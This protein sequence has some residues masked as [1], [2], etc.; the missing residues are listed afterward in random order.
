V[1]LGAG[2]KAVVVVAPNWLG[3]AVMALPALA[4]LRRHFTGARLA[5]AAR[6]SIAPLFEMVEGVDEV[7]TLPGSGGWRSIVTSDGDVAALASRFDIAILLPNSF[8]SALTARRA[9]IPERWGTAT[10]LRARLLTRA[11]ARP[12]GTLHQAAYYQA[13]VAA[14]GIPNG[15]R[16]A[17]VVVPRSTPG[18]PGTPGTRLRADEPPSASAGQALGTYVVLAPGAAYG[19]AKQWPPDRFA[20]LAALI[21]R[22]TDWNVVL[23]GSRADQAVC[24]SI[25]ADESRLI[26]LCGQTDLAALARILAGA[27]AVV[28]ND[29]GAMHLAGAVAARVIAVFGATNEHRT[30]PLAPGPDAPPPAILTHPVWCRPCMLRECPLDHR[31]MTGISAARVFAALD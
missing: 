5:V 28:T 7:V 30:S 11:V 3:D 2:G 16:Y 25:A 19:S 26:N 18:T 15:P 6:R 13:I 17:R 29:S 1:S 31:C 27:R 4:D 23:V 12:Q 21:V 20:E 22:H 9:G 8:A 24:A 14:F 10:D